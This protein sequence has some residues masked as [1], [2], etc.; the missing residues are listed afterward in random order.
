[1]PPAHSC[2]GN[3][4]SLSGRS[5]FSRLVYPAPEAAGL[6]VHLTL[7]LAGRARFGPDVEWIERVDYDVDPGRAEVFYNAIRSYWPDLKHGALHPADSGIRPKLPPR[8]RPEKGRGGKLK[9]GV[10]SNA[11]LFKAPEIKRAVQGTQAQIGEILLV[12]FENENPLF[13]VD[14]VPFL[15]TSYADAMKLYKAS[16]P[17]LEKLLAAQ[18]I[19]LLYV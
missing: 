6:G 18:G 2:K 12:N 5:P 19:K 10:P 13:G 4:F 11:S 17:A 15:A 14:G 16:R 9:I 7:D 3:Y 1:M 8:G